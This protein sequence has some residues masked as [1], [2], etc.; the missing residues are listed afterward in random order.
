MACKHKIFYLLFTPKK[1]FPLV[2][3]AI[4]LVTFS[5]ILFKIFVQIYKI[6]N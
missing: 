5:F 3:I 1:L 4:F 6:I 2:N